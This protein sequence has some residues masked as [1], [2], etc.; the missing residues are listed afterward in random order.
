MTITKTNTEIGDDVGAL[1]GVSREDAEDFLR[2]FY[3]QYPTTSPSSWPEVATFFGR[4]SGFP[5]GGSDGLAEYL[6]TQISGEQS[7]FPATVLDDPQLRDAYTPATPVVDESRVVRRGNEF[8][9]DGGDQVWQAHDAEGD[10][11]YDQLQNVYDELGQSVVP[12]DSAQDAEDD[13]AVGAEVGT[14]QEA[15]PAGTPVQPGSRITARDGRFHLDGTLEVWR[16]V[17]EQGP[18]F[19]DAGNRIFD[20]LGNQQVFPQDPAVEPA[21]RR[22]TANDPAAVD[23]ATRVARAIAAV[24]GFSLLSDAD[25][26]EVL[27]DALVDFR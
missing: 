5:Y 10:Y 8:F 2:A 15:V 4:L 13:T 23:L 9:L 16:A 3:R 17:D 27:A 1:L 26:L 11:Y 12:E 22:V 24:P 18:Y 19:Y 25:V 6:R 21:R 7:E 14:A 20:T